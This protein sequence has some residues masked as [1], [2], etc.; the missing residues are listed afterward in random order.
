MWVQQGS[1]LTPSDAAG[2]AQFGE[3]VA[4][5]ADGNTAVVGG[6]L[7]DGTVGAAWIFSRSGSTWT[8]VGPKLTG[9]GESGGGRFGSDVAVSGDGHTALIG[10]FT[11]ASNVGAAWVFVK[12]GSSWDQQGPKLTGSGEVGQG[13]FGQ[14]ALSADGNTAVVGAP[15]DN[16]DNGA[17]W[18]FTRAGSTWSQQ[19]PKLTAG[20]Q[21]EGGFGASVALSS[22][23][24]TALSGEPDSSSGTGWVFSRSGTS[25][26]RVVS[27]VS[28]VS[29]SRFGASAALSADGTTAVFGAPGDAPLNQTGSAWIFA[30][31]NGGSWTQVGSKLTASDETGAAQLGA[32]VALS[33]DGTTALIGG[34]GDNHTTGAAWAFTRTGAP[35]SYPSTLESTSGL[36]AYWR[37]GESSG[38]TAVDAVGGHN[39]T[40]TSG[41]TLGAAGAILGDAN[42]SVSLNGTTAKV[43]APSLGS[44]SDWTVQGWSYLDS[45][46][47]ENPNGDNALYA[48]GHGAR[49]IVRPSGFYFDDLSTGTSVGAKSGTTDSNIGRWVFW[50][51]VRSGFTLTLYRNGA[52]VAST[53]T[54][55]EGS[56]LLNGTIGAQGAAYYL[57]GR[58]DEVS[59]SDAALTANTVQ[60]LY[61]C[62]GWG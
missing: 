53:S 26:K 19:G 16:H 58:I 7:D 46:A 37:L 17:M 4:V 62:S 22:D 28:N 12:S 10:G 27:F 43:N 13:R 30:R 45:T 36:L 25:W 60:T 32:S 48:S 57:H 9:G 2:K 6:D 8:Q 29:E 33:G 23:G 38:R 50:T 42:T 20:D 47:S 5:S 61:A 52:S 35:C 14:V 15:G 51:L 54:A 18:A 59:V 55:A 34:S 24:A 1:K 39:G 56:T 44:A 31:R 40:Y 49:L 21:F 41:V 3:S 11:D